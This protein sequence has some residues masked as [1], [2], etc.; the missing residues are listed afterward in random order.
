MKY[1]LKSFIMLKY[2]K[3][4]STLRK[5]EIS[6]QALSTENIKRTNYDII[7]KAFTYQNLRHFFIERSFLY[8]AAVSW[9]Q[10]SVENV[11]YQKYQ[12]LSKSGVLALGSH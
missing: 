2:T 10:V 11:Q 5:G 7:I 9:P 1:I 12:K 8:R 3:I 4:Q 6:D